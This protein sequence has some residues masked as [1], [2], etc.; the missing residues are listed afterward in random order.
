M[1]PV[2]AAIAAHFGIQAK[3]ARIVAVLYAA[4][5]EFVEFEPLREACGIASQDALKVHVW[6]IRNGGVAL[7]V[8]KRNGYRLPQA[9]MDACREALIDAVAR[10][11]AAAE[12]GAA[13]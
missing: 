5:G 8:E 11:S 1:N 6:W 7:D 13:A 4:K 9:S 3:Q 2:A 12:T 10:L